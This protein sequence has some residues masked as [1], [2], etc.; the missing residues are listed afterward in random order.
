M[1]QLSQPQIRRR[2]IFELIGKNCQDDFC[3]AIM[4]ITDITAGAW[5]LSG[6]IGHIHGRAKEEGNF[7]S[8]LLLV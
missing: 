5:K 7:F 2:L 8:V 3:L 4:N 1:G 6:F